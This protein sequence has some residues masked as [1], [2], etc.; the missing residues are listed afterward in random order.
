MAL[1]MF[2]AGLSFSIPD[3][4]S[5]HFILLASMIYLFCA[6]YSP[7]MGP[8]PNTYCA[9]VFPL[10]HREVGMS[11][12]VATANFWASV[13]SV[14]FPRMLTALKP[15]GAFIL[16]AFL[17]LLAALLVFLFVPET[18][19]KTLDELDDV[20]SIPSRRFLKYQI[21]EYLPWVTRYYILRQKQAELRPLTLTEEY[22][23]LD[24]DDY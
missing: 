1:T 17:N 23:E 18:R 19:Q 15:Q 24:Q 21:T 11:M 8:V 13:L 7:G 10:S 2:A 9:E 3:D 14:T 20:F 4:N 6:E 5:A 12:A 22:R 16:Y